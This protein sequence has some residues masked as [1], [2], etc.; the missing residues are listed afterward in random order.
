MTWPKHPVIYEINAWVWLMELSRRHHRRLTLATVPASEWNALAELDIDAVWFMG[1]WERSPAGRAIAMEN[2]ELQK[3]FRRALPDLK[4]E[5]VVGSPYCVRRYVVD[6]LLGGPKGLAA[7]RKELA[8]RDLQLILDLVPNHVAPDHSWVSDHPEY[9]IRGDADDLDRDRAS[10]FEADG[11][12]FAR[13]R[14]PYFPAWPDVLQLNAFNEGLRRATIETLLT[15][16]EQADGVRCD[17]AMLVMNQVFAQTWGDRAGPQPP[18]GFWTTVIPAVK[19]RFPD[20]IF[21]GEAYWDLEWQLQMHGFDYCYDKRLYD[22]ICHDSAE[23]V[24]S[25]LLADLAY[26][27]KLVRFIEN[28]D[29]PRAA[30]VFSPG[31]EIAAA[32]AIMTLP[33]A[34]LLHEG[35]LE[36][37]KVRLPVFLARRPDEPVQPALRDFYSRLLKMVN[38][39]V[40]RN[41]HWILC[42]R[43]GW[44][45][46]SSFQNLAAWCWIKDDDRYLVV[47]N[48]SD[49]PSQG[50]VK[51]PWE[52]LQTETRLTDALSGE[53]YERNGDE[54]HDPGLFVELNAWAAHCFHVEGRAPQPPVSTRRRRWAVRPSA[55]GAAPKQTSIQTHRHL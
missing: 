17:M 31:Q 35:Q 33:G 54:M 22:R 41:G 40:F 13:G 32:T 1:V 4:A 51:A 34:K 5:D 39:E 42:E 52:D 47:V 6:E 14:D 50:L 19:K 15:I 36:G 46:N 18:R 29:E 37:R 8:E 53:V 11:N 3:N 16:A 21:I 25:H 28:H 24:R 26:Q 12:I 7:A 55:F 44:P 27:E 49:T 2:Q 10:F 38:R 30:A 43:S 9:F 20:F 45:D 23:Y 48:L